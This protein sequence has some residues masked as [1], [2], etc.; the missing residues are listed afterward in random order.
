MTPSLILKR[1]QSTW[2]KQTGKVGFQRGGKE[3]NLYTGGSA[4]V[5]G[6]QGFERKL[7]HKQF[8][9]VGSIRSGGQAHYLLRVE[10]SPA[11][12]ALGSFISLPS[13]VRE[14][15][16]IPR[17]DIQQTVESP[18]PEKP[19]QLFLEAYEAQV[20]REKTTK[21]RPR[22]VVR[23]HDE[24]Q[25]QS[26]VI[27]ARPS[28]QYIRIYLKPVETLEA[29]KKKKFQLIR[30]EVELK[31][32]ISNNVVNSIVGKDELDEKLVQSFSTV[33]AGLEEKTVLTKKMR[34]NVAF[35]SGA[36]G[37]PAYRK[38]EITSNTLEWFKNSCFPTFKR[39]L[40]TP[41]TYAEASSVLDD[42]IIYRD[43]IRV[44]FQGEEEGE[45]EEEI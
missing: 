44:V 25:N 6:Y 41:E 43:N 40:D 34:E 9:F 21:K 27:G 20:E 32:P 29:G 10:K 18:N 37:W 42:L 11:Q 7:N 39:L 23:F 31:P 3:T 5:G 30:A 15:F 26:I 24:S 28:P 22:K 2:E 45:D 1:Y 35:F 16:N 38:L 14:D 8:L 4:F 19:K 17:L 12:T 36:L 13:I 33:L